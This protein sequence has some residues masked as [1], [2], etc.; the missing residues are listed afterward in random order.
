MEI[1][2][3][4]EATAFYE[5][6]YELKEEVIESNEKIKNLIDKYKKDKLTPDEA[7]DLHKYVSE[8]CYIN[9]SEMLDIDDF[10]FESIKDYE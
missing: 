7:Y 6:G 4:E 2:F 10:K 9:T 8:H 3:L 5:V 1:K